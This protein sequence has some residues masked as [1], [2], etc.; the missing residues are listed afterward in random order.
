LS[1]AIVVLAFKSKHLR[2]ITWKH[3]LASR[4]RETDTAGM[5][6]R[7]RERE[8]ERERE[9]DAAGLRER[10][11]ERKIMQGSERERKGDVAGL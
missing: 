3:G 10:E 9:T 7:K 1:T 8:R 4:V 2:R 5:K 6:E 11:R